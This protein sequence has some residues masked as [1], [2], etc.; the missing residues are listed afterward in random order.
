MLAQALTIP[1]IGV[2]VFTMAFISGQ[3]TAA[4]GVDN[5]SLPPGGRRPPTLWRVLGTIV[6][7]V[8]IS[9]SAVDVLVQ[10]MPPVGAHPAVHRRR[11]AFVPAG[12]QRAAARARA[13]GDHGEPDE[14]RHGGTLLFVCAA[15]LF[16]S[17][18][19]I[20]GLPE[21]P[22]QSWTLI[23]GVLGVVFIGV[24]TMTVAR[25]GVLA[26]ESDVA[27]RKPA[28]FPRDRPDLPLRPRRG[29]PHHLP[30]D[31]HRPRRR[32]RL[33]TSP[34]PATAPPD[35]AA[36]ADPASVPLVIEWTRAG[37]R[38]PLDTKGSTRET[39]RVS[40][41]G[42]C[43]PVR[44]RR[45]GTARRRRAGRASL[46]RGAGKPAGFA[47]SESAARTSSETLARITG[48]VVSETAT[49]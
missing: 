13:V 8:G 38:G 20:E 41:S 16:A 48:D 22:G 46:D 26:A 34:A 33:P 14:L 31:G 3:L 1:L 4:L 18:A 42:G 49:A 19:R 12:V 17:G 10:G 45:R 15:A 2:S 9:L 6:V 39:A 35:P 28:R 11:D 24:T 5:T 27:V 23:G 47:S 40:G 30:V 25:L 7:L 44:R 36:R 21:I 29:E 37:S 43:G 32:P